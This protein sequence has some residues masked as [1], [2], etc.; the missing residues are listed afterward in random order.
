MQVRRKFI[1]LTQKTCLLQNATWIVLSTSCAIPASFHFLTSSSHPCLHL[2]CP[3]LA[4]KSGR[5]C[6]LLMS[7]EFLHTGLVYKPESGRRKPTKQKKSHNAHQTEKQKNKTCVLSA[8][9]LAM[10]TNK[11]LLKSSSTCFSSFV[12]LFCSSRVAVNASLL[13]ERCT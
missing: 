12:G 8:K 11:Q 5:S 10:Y 1:R 4:M 13:K 9:L 2:S 6:V 7:T 3:L